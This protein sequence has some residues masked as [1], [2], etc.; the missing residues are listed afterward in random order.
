[1]CLLLCG[2]RGRGYLG[3]PPAAV[4]ATG[5]DAER[6]DA[7]RGEGE[8]DGEVIIAAF[9]GVADSGGI[10]PIGISG[11]GNPGVLGW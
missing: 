11:E 7:E 9:S 5:V 1:M 4:A 6:G 2:C 3:P 8:S 10:T